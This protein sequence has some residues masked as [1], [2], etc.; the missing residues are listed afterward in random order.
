MPSRAVLRSVADVLRR[1]GIIVYPTDTAYAIGGCFNRA[2]VRRRVLAIKGRRD[3]K[4]TLVAASL[5]QV[6]RH[7]RLHPTARHVARRYWPGPLSIVVSPRFAVRV[8]N[9]AVA[10]TL[11]R[12]AGAPLIATSANRSG[13]QTPYTVAAVRRQLT[14]GRQ[15][16]MM[17]D[18]GRLPQRKPS[19]IVRVD[20]RGQ[21]R[22]IRAGGVKV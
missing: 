15:P 18:A 11:A 3:R 13:G 9:S 4:F 7:F 6:L 16:A 22:V 20:G 1:G 8:P 19:T 5:A 21:V 17:V 14:L 2:V 12:L 10:R